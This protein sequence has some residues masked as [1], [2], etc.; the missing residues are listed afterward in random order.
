MICFLKKDLLQ[1]TDQGLTTINATTSK[2]QETLNMKAIL[3]R[4]YD[5]DHGTIGV[6]S[7]G[8]FT[9][10]TIEPPWRDNLPNRSCIPEGEY[11]C[12]WHHSPRY[13]WVYLVSDV[14][15]RSHIL[16]HPGNL[17]GDKD[18]GFHTHTLGCILLGQKRGKLI[19]K[20]KQQEAVLVSRPTC[21]SFYNHME[22]TTFQLEVRS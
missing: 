21:R 19:I 20:K 10:Y 4:L 16:I 12:V 22:E 5:S 15:D 2:A 1:I 18:K 9:C 14:P 7:C 3:K 17:G 8:D 6:L 11:Y 13:G